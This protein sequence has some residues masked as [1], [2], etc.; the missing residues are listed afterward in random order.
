MVEATADRPHRERHGDPHG[1]I[2]H[3]ENGGEDENCPDI[4]GDPVVHQVADHV[5]QIQHRKMTGE[6]FWN[7]P[8]FDLVENRCSR[9][10]E[11][12]QIYRYDRNEDL[13]AGEGK[14]I[15][16]FVENGEDDADDDRTK[17]AK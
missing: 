1:E 12:Q 14:A 13:D 9:L 16:R 7:T 15:R 2:Y 8:M 6:R 10:H 3:H 4:K 11:S 5:R 17:P